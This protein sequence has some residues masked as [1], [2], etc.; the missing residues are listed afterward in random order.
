MHPHPRPALKRGLVPAP[1]Q[2][3]TPS[4]P[5]WTGPTEGREGQAAGN[6]GAD[7]VLHQPGSKSQDDRHTSSVSR[8]T[9]HLPPVLILDK[10]T[11]TK[12][13]CI[14][15]SRPWAAMAPGLDSLGEDEKLSHLLDSH[16]FDLARLI[17]LDPQLELRFDAI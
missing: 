9:R 13:F 6:G 17:A 11:I 12:P 16:R 5:A 1:A 4:A 8:P 15:C 10:A 7:A 14:F 2:Q 3:V